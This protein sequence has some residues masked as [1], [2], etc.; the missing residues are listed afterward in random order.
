VPG[1]TEGTLMWFVFGVVIILLLLF[2][3]AMWNDYDMRKK[4]D[5]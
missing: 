3:W 1:R 5:D 2:A 4:D